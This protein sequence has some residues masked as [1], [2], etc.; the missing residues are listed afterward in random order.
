MGAVR[1]QLGTV[2]ATLERSHHR[3]IEATKT[4]LEKVILGAEPEKIAGF[5]IADGARDDEGWR[6]GCALRHDPQ[7]L[8]S[9]K[10][11]QIA[12]KQCQRGRLIDR[13][14]EFCT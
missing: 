10:I 9:P 13:V 14:L 7:S 2:T 5:F 1:A 12:V 4:I 11:R 8:A 6:I 3:S